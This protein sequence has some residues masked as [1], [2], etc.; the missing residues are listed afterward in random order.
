M[1]RLIPYAIV[2]FGAGIGGM[3]RHAVNFAVP[4]AL[5]GDF[6]WATPIINVSGSVVMGLLVGWL[7]FKTSGGWTQHMRLFAATGVLG[8][9]TTFSTFSLETA[10]LIERSAYGSALAYAF[11][12]VL[13]GVIGLFAG[14]AI[15][16]SL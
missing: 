6:P 4:K 7:T 1:D 2:F 11:G 14:L 3:I 9:Y 5:T 12:S 15:M 13:L 8:G 10:L 16:R